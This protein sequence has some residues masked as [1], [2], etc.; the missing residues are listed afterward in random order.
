MGG[1]RVFKEI[2]LAGLLTALIIGPAFSASAPEPVKF[3]RAGWLA[4]YAQLKT[5]LQ[6]TYVNLVW[7]G[8]FEGG[9]DLPRLDQITRAA[10]VA[11][12]DDEEARAVLSA[13]VAAFHDGHL[14]TLPTLSAPLSPS[15]AKVG[16]PVFEASDPVKSCAG[17]GFLPNAPIAFSQGFESL[18]NFTL[19]TDGLSTVY[20]TGI[21][22]TAT[23]ARI[24][25]IRIQNFRLR[26]FP[27]A[28]TVAWNQ[29]VQAK[30]AITSDAVRQAAYDLWFDAFRD[31]MQAWKAEG[32]AAVLIDVGNNSGGDDKGD[33]FP[34][35]LTDKQVQSA[36]LAV[37]AAPAGE[38]YMNEEIDTLNEA[39]A[40]KLTPEP[41]NAFI[42]ARD[43]FLAQK[44]RIKT[45]ACDVSW[46]WRK[47]RHW[48]KVACRHTVAAGFAGGYSA[49]LP[50]GAYGDRDIASQLAWSSE[51]DDKFGTW[52]GPVYVLTDAKTFSAA[53]MF[54]AAMQNNGIGKIV[55]I[56]T[57]GAGCGF[58]GESEP[59]VLKHSHLR[60]RV[61]NCMRLRKDG[62][63]EVAGIRPDIA[64]LPSENEDTN[65][66]TERLLE[67]IDTDL[68]R[69]PK[70]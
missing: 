48:D 63:N 46:V 31:Q 21:A 14:S 55:G 22:T 36:P 68:K 70:P 3:D 58:M 19:T 41:R 20:R 65:Q 62:T 13:F 1:R 23:G 17:L 35:M 24:G 6:K 33:Y 2:C 18:P 4:D 52:A 54:T 40:G 59:V 45:D 15:P 25:I 27:G 43:Y 66:R 9:V 53:E 37:V 51:I 38:G 44:S 57:G 60:F 50:K 34:R 8:T 5:D 26:A 64:I 16:R 30:A 61:P 56:A 28:C 39:L 47:R 29:L 42:E 32:I 49:G 69:G 10:L 7:F 11:A 12:R 67:T